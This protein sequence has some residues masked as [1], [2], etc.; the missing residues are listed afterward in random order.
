MR[1]SLLLAV[2]TATDK[3]GAVVA[4]RL[5]PEAQALAEQAAAAAPAGGAVAAGKAA[6]VGKVAATAGAAVAAKGAGS[7]V[8]PSRAIGVDI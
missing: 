5:S 2:V 7:G 4:P 1:D 6:A 3:S 8:C